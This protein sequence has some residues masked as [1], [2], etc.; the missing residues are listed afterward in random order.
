MEV[1]LKILGFGATNNSPQNYPVVWHL[2][3]LK[4]RLEQRSPA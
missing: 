3:M 1:S 4:R 2:Q